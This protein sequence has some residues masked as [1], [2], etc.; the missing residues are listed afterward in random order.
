MF[1]SWSSPDGLPRMYYGEQW[2]GMVIVFDVRER[3]KHSY[4]DRHLRTL[5]GASGRVKMQSTALARQY[6]NGL[7]CLSCVLLSISDGLLMRWLGTLGSVL[8][9]EIW[10]HPRITL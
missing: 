4:G 3:C 7:C 9:H 8:P 5:F 6:S 1:G 10:L 2:N